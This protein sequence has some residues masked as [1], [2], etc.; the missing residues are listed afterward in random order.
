MSKPSEILDFVIG[1]ITPKDCQL[2]N[3]SYHLNYLPFIQNQ[4]QFSYL[5]E[6]VQ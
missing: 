6:K 5:L 1:P 3:H 4:L 2:I